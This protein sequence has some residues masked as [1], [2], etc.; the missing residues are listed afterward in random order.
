[1]TT[2]GLLR[3]VALFLLVSAA[4]VL[5]ATV[6]PHLAWRGVVPDVVL[7]VVVATALVKGSQVAMVTGF[8]AGVLLDVAPPAD[9]VAGR[10]ALALVLV[11]YVAG[12]V[13]PAEKRAGATTA[14]FTVAVCA[15]TGTS[16][17]ALT[18]LLLHD[19]V[20]PLTQLFEA[21]GVGVLLDLLLAPLLLPPVMGLLRRLEPQRGSPRSSGRARPALL[22]R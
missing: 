6:L 10:W 12:L 18:G 3:A 21:V 5:Q 20:V 22:A 17:F 7:L 4:L 15:F 8:A 9:H 13:A 19:P 16:V 14:M 11:G 2:T 1:M